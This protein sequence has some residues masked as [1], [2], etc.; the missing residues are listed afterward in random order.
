MYFS[1]NYYGFKTAE[2]LS[3]HMSHPDHTAQ[4]IKGK[5]VYN[6]LKSVWYLN[7]T[8]IQY[9]PQWKH[10]QSLLHENQLVLFSEMVIL[11]SENHRTLISTLCW[12]NAED[13]VVKTGY[14]DSYH[15]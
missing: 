7:S 10:W 8:T 11:P 14:T 12:Q 6:P 1:A 9:I 2:V 3:Y 5:T 15:C 4:H 13:L